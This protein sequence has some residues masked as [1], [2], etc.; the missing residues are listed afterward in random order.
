[1]HTRTG[2][3]GEISTVMR[4][5]VP[6][7]HLQQQSNATNGNAKLIV[8]HGYCAQKNPF[9]V[10]PEDWTDAM[11]YSDPGK[12]IG[13]DEFARNVSV[14]VHCDLLLIDG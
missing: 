4:Q 13:I 12:G 6:P 2:Y 1:M 8:V 14:G 7:L 5:G 10:Y 9:A 11:F 3:Q